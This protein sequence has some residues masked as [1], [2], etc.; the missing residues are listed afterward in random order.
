MEMNIHDLLDQNVNQHIFNI[1]SIYLKCMLK[2]KSLLMRLLKAMLKRNPYGFIWI[3][4]I[5]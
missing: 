1:F 3:I 2:P 4:I 5:R